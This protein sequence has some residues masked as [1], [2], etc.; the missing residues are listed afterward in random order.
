MALLIVG[1][2]GLIGSSLKLNSE[3][4]C[5]DFP[6]GQWTSDSFKESLEKSI[7]ESDIK[8]D[9]LQI[10]WAAGKSNMDSS[11][12]ILD[13]EI[14]LIKNFLQI[15]SKYS[16]SINSLSFIS[17]A[18]SIYGGCDNQTITEETP[19]NPITDYGRSRLIL[20]EIFKNFGST[21]TTPIN[22]FRLSNVFGLKKNINSSSGLI[23]NLIK[24]NLTR[25]DLNIFVPLTT[26]QDYIDVDFV[27][28]N[29]LSILTSQNSRKVPNQ[30]FIFSRNYSHSIVEILSIIDRFSR[31]KTTYLSHSIDSSISRQNNLRF[32]V[33]NSFFISSKIEPITLTIHKLI[34]QVYSELKI[35]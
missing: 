29:I 21:F 7:L 2:T 13:D 5:I 12:K 18:G 24:A 26:A 34:Q 25:K 9:S 30:T 35:N 11:T 28:R 10:V 3:I 1:Q 15:I 27:S 31:R 14:T 19:P 22:I 32:N 23:L 33:N 4:N 16:S 8:E 17:S 20:E 6:V